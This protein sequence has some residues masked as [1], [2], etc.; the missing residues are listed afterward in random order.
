MNLKNIKLSERNQ[1]K[2]L[3]IIWLFYLY[4]MSRIYKSIK[5]AFI[6]VGGREG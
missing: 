6:S 2:G 4:E 3:D 5:M 1:Y